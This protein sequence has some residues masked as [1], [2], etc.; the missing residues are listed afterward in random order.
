MIVNTQIHTL[1]T[2]D[3]HTPNPELKKLLAEHP[4]QTAIPDPSSISR[5]LSP[6]LPI[7]EIQECLI[8]RLGLRQVT[9]VLGNINP[10][11]HSST[12]RQLRYERAQIFFYQIMGTAFVRATVKVTLIALGLFVFFKTTPKITLLYTLGAI[13]SLVA[14]KAFQKRMDPNLA[15]QAVRFYKA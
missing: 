9:E 11:N 13:A 10:M 5:W 2:P 6:V 12:D 7:R 8:A 15:S 14:L 4:I 1:F 3:F